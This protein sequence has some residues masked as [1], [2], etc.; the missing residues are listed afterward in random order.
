MFSSSVKIRPVTLPKGEEEPGDQRVLGLALSPVG[1]RAVQAILAEPDGG[2][3]LDTL[4][5]EISYQHQLQK[6]RTAASSRQ[7]AGHNR[8]AARN[9]LS[10]M[11][12]EGSVRFSLGLP[13]QAELGQAFPPSALAPETAARFTLPPLC[14]VENSN[15]SND[16]KMQRFTFAELFAVSNHNCPDCSFTASVR[17][18][19]DATRLFCN[20][21]AFRVGGDNCARCRELTPLAMIR[22]LRACQQ[23]IGGFRLGLES[24]GGRCILMAEQDQACHLTVRKNFSEECATCS[25]QTIVPR[26]HC[27]VD[28][29]T[30]VS[31]VC[32]SA[33]AS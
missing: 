30:D 6:H 24:I 13:C 3:H 33:L 23:G 31:S 18:G 21:S 11:L 16:A 27:L 29:Y 14:S 5:Q 25:V 9:L 4:R 20:R 12:R 10:A 1:V 8:A 7:S 19:F 17:L 2:Q 32:K 15:D 22:V 28:H 26:F